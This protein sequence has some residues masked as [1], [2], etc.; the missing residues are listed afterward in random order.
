[1][2]RKISTVTA[3]IAVTIASLVGLS[4]VP[5]VATAETY[6]A[7]KYV[8][9]D[10]CYRA[11]K[12]PGTYVYDTRG[13]P[14]TGESRSWSGNMQSNGAKIRNRWNAPVFIQTERMVE[15]QHVTLVPV[16]C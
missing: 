13:I 4:A 6:S 12:V 1:M 2:K 3:A 16:P 15:D 14:V 10:V 5:G 9:R 11:R 8:N 7:R